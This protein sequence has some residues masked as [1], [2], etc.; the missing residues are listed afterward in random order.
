MGPDSEDGTKECWKCI[1]FI[2]AV[3]DRHQRKVASDINLGSI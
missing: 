3:Y 1:P 2:L